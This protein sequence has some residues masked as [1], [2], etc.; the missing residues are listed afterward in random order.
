[1]LCSP[2]QQSR[3][4]RQSDNLRHLSS[5]DDTDRLHSC[6]GGVSSNDLWKILDNGER[7]VG[8]I[9]ELVSM[10]HV[11]SGCGDQVVVHLS[12][13]DVGICSEADL[14]FLV[15]HLS[16]GLWVSEIAAEDASIVTLLEFYWRGHWQ[17]PGMAS[18]S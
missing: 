11:H 16:L 5:A 9:A 13:Q 6:L 1:M 8:D 7:S 12:A 10:F 4:V 14:W 15:H 3:W 2:Y 17:N 18:G